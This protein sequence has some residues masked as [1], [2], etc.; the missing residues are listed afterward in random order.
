MAIP[1][2]LPT[3]PYRAISLDGLDRD[4]SRKGKLAAGF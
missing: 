4:L 2:A 3:L 1:W